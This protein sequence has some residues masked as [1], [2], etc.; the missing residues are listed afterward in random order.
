MFAFKQTL[1]NGFTIDD[2]SPLLKA[3]F[4]RGRLTAAQAR[5]F[6]AFPNCEAQDMLFVQLGSLVNDAGIIKA[7]ERGDTVLPI[8]NDFLILPSR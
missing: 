8:E 7:I 2:L 1:E 4:L 6:A 3:R 5:A